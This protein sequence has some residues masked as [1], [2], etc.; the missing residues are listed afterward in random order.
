MAE[1]PVEA[2][3]VMNVIKN[4]KIETNRIINNHYDNIKNRFQFGFKPTTEFDKYLLV[5]CKNDFKDY[6]TWKE[7]SKITLDEMLNK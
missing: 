7:C 4:M 2:K 6:K 1:N 5:N 3:S